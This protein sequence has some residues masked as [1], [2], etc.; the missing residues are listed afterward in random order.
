MSLARAENFRVKEKR[1]GVI[2]REY[3]T[4]RRGHHGRQLVKVADQD[5]LHTPERLLAV[6]PEMA[7]KNIDAIQKVRAH[8][9][10]FVDDNGIKVLVKQAFVP[11]QADLPRRL[12]R[13]IG[14][15]IEK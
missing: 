10:H 7:Q 8:H 2:A 12:G 13:D 5:H 4:L 3:L 9:G 6:R 14:P 11:A 1:A 15:E